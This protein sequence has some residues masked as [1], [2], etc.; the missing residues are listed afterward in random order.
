MING[1]KKTSGGNMS[2]L[3]GISRGNEY[4]YITHIPGR[5][6]PCLC[7]GNGCVI[8]TI[9]YFHSEEYAEKFYKMLLDW[10]NLRQGDE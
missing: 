10:F 9:A 7:I 5:K 1:Q 4:I 6:K 8:Q 2:N 3:G